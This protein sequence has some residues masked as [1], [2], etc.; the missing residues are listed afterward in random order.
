MFRRSMKKLSAAWALFASSSKSIART[1]SAPP[2]TAA[3]TRSDSGLKTTT[4]LGKWR[5]ADGKFPIDSSGTL[6]NG[7]SF[8]TPAEMKIILKAQLPD[9]AS[10]L[11]EKLL[12]Y[13][14]G[15]GLE[16][17]DK[18]TVEEI[19]KNLAASDY[20]FQALINEIVKSLPFQSRRGEAVTTENSAKPK[21]VAQR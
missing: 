8:G 7:K 21:E 4:P 1:P 2:A 10:C 18:K 3:W 9:F 20:Q 6:P 17:Y 19:N 14:L 15:R 13:S 11:I 12:T 5:S 16:R